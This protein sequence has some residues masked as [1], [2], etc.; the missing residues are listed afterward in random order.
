MKCPVCGNWVDFF[1]ICEN[2]GYQNQGVNED[3]GLRGPNKMTLTE[4]KEAY[5]D[6]REIY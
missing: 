3:N 5:K 2:C 6:G 1:D 4:A